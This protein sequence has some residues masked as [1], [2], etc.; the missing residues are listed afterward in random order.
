MIDPL[1]GSKPEMGINYFG[2]LLTKL[3]KKGSL[4]YRTHVVVLTLLNLPDDDLKKMI[5]CFY[6]H[7]PKRLPNT[8]KFCSIHVLVNKGF[9][10]FKLKNCVR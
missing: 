7:A 5:F 9:L 1:K 2:I 4:K 8:S 6:C 10:K 3:T